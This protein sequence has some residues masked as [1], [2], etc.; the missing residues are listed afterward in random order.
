MTVLGRSDILCFFGVF[1]ARESQFIQLV[2]SY[3][4]AWLCQNSYFEAM[5]QSK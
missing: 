4:P 3:Y 1:N 2:E 5:A